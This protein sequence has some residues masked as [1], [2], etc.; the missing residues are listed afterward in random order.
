MENVSHAFPGVS[1]G[2]AAADELVAGVS[3]KPGDIPCL[4]VTSSQRF[5][6]SLA[7]TFL[8]GAGVGYLA[9]DRPPHAA[10]GVTKHAPDS[11]HTAAPRDAAEASDEQQREEAR[12]EGAAPAT[13]ADIASSIL[14]AVRARD[15]FRR[16][17]DIYAVGQQLDR[18]TILT[19]MEATQHFPESD[20]ENARYPLLARWLELDATAAYEWVNAVPKQSQRTDL[21]R[22][23][24]HS[25][26]MKDPAAALRFLKQYKASPNRGE[27][28]TYS[29]IE[30]WSVHDPVAAVDAALSLPKDE[31]RASGLSVALGRWAKRDPEGALARAAQFPDAEARSNHLGTI[32]REWAKEDPQAA[33]SH[34]LSLPA[35]KERNDA[36]T[37]V[38]SGAAATD[39]EAVKRLI[40]QMP[41]GAAR[42]ATLSRIVSNLGYKEPRIAA[43][44]VLELPP[45][46][47]R[48]L[49]HQV[50]HNFARQDRAGAL[51][52]AG[53]L[54][55]ADARRTAVRQIVQ[56]WSQDDPKG[57]AE[58]C[59]S[60]PLGTSEILANAVGN[61]ARNDASGA[62]AWAGA[63]PD[64]AQREAAL[65]R[66][67]G[68]LGSSDPN[69]AVALAA[70]ML[71]DKARDDALGNIASAW[72]AKD[73][74]AAAAWAAQLTDATARA[75]AIMQI[76]SRW[77][78]QDPAAAAAWVL[79]TPGSAHGLSQISRD[80]A[81]Q[82]PAAAARWLET[83]P[84][85]ESRDSAVN[86][87]SQAVIEVDPET[88]VVWALTIAKPETRDMAAA[89]LYLRWKNTDSKA[90]AAW[91]RATP[92]LSEEVKARL[93][94]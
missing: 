19:A 76:A 93:Q 11:A 31:S 4:M 57:A 73:P 82:D 63:L 8:L 6:T 78:R 68:A 44:L 16:R 2:L 72:A 18:D 62:L 67:I 53:Q 80:W 38:A 79:Q 84:A 64:P 48:D 89:N 9:G 7:L 83:L 28:F 55:S 32:L 54:S 69:R 74:A 47:Q 61:W 60:S 3:G 20:R 43:E 14:S 56:Q 92:A 81:T 35:G 91:L 26:G 17:H 29:V 27:D 75:N 12:R 30:A 36:I 77:G 94:R 5:I 58:Y 10:P 33:T 85:G 25:L 86:S 45:G 49:V 39:P 23:F 1:S 70:T 65:A 15:Y 24:F 13:D 71:G 22:E 87:F 88:A 40:A 41:P 59:V 21:M 34:A 66:A 50:I 90:A 51:E 42:N 52:W 37:S 46:Q